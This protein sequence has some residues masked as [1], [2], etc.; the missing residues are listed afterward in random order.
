MTHLYLSETRIT[1]AALAELVGMP[2]LVDLAV[3]ETRVSDAGLAYVERMPKLRTLDVTDSR[4]TEKAAEAVHARKKV[5]IHSERWED[6]EDIIRFPP[7]KPN[8][9][10]E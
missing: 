1:D 6:V 8:A 4:V 9:T 3:R 10:H 5:W 7:R 2:N